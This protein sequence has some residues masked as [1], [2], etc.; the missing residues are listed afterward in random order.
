MGGIGYDFAR[1]WGP[2]RAVIITVI[3]AI[4]RKSKIYING[5]TVI[6]TIRIYI[7]SYRCTV[8]PSDIGLGIH[9]LPFRVLYT[10]YIHTVLEGE[11]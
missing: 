3:I 5:E 4:T 2:L 6:I 8:P 11:K 9:F 7:H 1:V 10:G